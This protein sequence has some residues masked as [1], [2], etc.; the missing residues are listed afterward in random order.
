MS[1]VAVM[2]V[3]NRPNGQISGHFGK[4]EWTMAADTESHSFVFLKN[5]AS[6]GSS[7]VD[8]LVTQHCTDAIFTQIGSG[9]LGHLASANIRG[10]I[11]PP[12]ITGQQAVEL[13]QQQQLQPAASAT[14][15]HSGGC[16]CGKRDGSES[17]PGCHRQSATGHA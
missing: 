1:K 9:A 16:C 8:L 17:S 11:A 5:D 3:D 2:M 15:G 7:L 4:A 12:N 13:F 10:W 6:C 14:E